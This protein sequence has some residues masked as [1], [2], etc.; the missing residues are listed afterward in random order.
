[1]WAKMAGSL[2]VLVAMTAGAF[3]GDSP[4][5]S[6]EAFQ[7]ICDQA[8]PD[9][10]NCD[11]HGFETLMTIAYP[12]LKLQKGA[13]AY[14]FQTELERYR[15]E[16]GNPIDWKCVGQKKI[17]SALR[18]YVY[19]CRYAKQLVCWSLTAQEQN[20]R[21]SLYG[22]HFECGPGLPL[23]QFP[24]DGPGK[25]VDCL[26]LCGRVADLFAHGK[27]EAA[28]TF[29]KNFTSEDPAAFAKFAEAIN[30]VLLAVSWS[31][32]L[33]KCE[34]VSA[35]DVGGVA[36]EYCYLMQW[37]RGAA[38]VRFQ[39]YRAREDWKLLGFFWDADANS[40]FAKVPMESGQLS[41]SPQTARAA[42]TETK[43]ELR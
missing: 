15:Q 29:R 13:L 41:E 6:A 3:G 22:F 23:G 32:N 21:W 30:S 36:G 4:V 26:R 28:E 43:T 16:L 12:Q 18:Q 10:L 27:T 35:K 8:M 40:M 5:G 33:L 9:L 39:V 42:K 1:M 24:S 19:V 14:R 37:D 31:G 2:V 17:G 11:V 25:N 34:L 7:K 20:G 38:V